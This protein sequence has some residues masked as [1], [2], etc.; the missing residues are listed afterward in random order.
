MESR[1][2]L[3]LLQQ[4]QKELDSRSYLMRLGAL[5][6]DTVLLEIDGKEYY[7]Y[8]ERGRLSRIAA[9]Q[10]RCTPWRFAVRTDSEALQEF[11]RRFPK[12]GFHDIF[13]LAK[14]GR[15]RIEGDILTLVRNL[16]FFKEFIA[17]PREL[18]AD[19][20]ARYERGD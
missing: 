19:S 3:S 16:R 1:E 20:E 8:F 5:F 2:V 7:L 15:A 11:W 13:G 10:S 9:G 14:I 4:M 17:L 6:S 18:P 12:P